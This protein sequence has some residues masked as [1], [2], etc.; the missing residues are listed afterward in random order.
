MALKEG[1]EFDFEERERER[2]GVCF[3]GDFDLYAIGVGQVRLSY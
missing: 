3:G 1:G 2:E